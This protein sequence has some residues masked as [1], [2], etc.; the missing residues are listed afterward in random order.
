MKVTFRA[1]P[2]LLRIGE[3]G[4]SIV[5]AEDPF[6]L[7]IVDRVSRHYGA[8]TPT[9]RARSRC[10]RFF[11]RAHYM[12]LATATLVRMTYTREALR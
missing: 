10:R 12:S 1:S 11:H 6:R 3:I 7:A 4:E 9:P 8:A 5:D 2:E